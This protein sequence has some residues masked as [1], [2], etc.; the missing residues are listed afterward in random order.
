MQAVKAQRKQPRLDSTYNPNILSS[1]PTD[2]KELY[3]YFR[4]GSELKLYVA[5]DFAE[6]IQIE[7]L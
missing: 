2:E 4:S 3:S 7:R 1:R 5:F 6:D